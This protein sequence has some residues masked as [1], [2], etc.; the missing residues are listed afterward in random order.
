VG[1]LAHSADADKTDLDFCAHHFTQGLRIMKPHTYR[2]HA[3]PAMAAI[4][5]IRLLLLMPFANVQNLV[6][7][8]LQPRR[9]WRMDFHAHAHHE[10][11][12]VLNG[13]IFVEIQGKTLT[14]G[15]GETL[16]Y[17]QRVAHREWTSARAPVESHFMAFD[18][19]ELPSPPRLLVTDPE[20]RLIQL[21]RWLYAERATDPSL[22]Q[23]TATLYGQ[24]LVAEFLRLAAQPADGFVARMRIF[25]R[26]HLADEITL[27][28]LAAAAAL[29]RFHFIRRY[30]AQTG[31]TPMADLRL[32]RL[33]AARDLL[34]TTSLPLKE[35]APRCGLRDEFHLSRL[36]RRQF[37]TSPG[38]FRRRRQG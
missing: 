29:S 12:V 28:D 31:R 4:A 36:F 9:T 7:G 23:P 5:Y 11:I 21:A 27:E 22:T 25:M 6:I 16:W 3:L 32:T 1:A 10:M 24:A 14:A 19:P 26:Q 8:H 33:A 18:W 37:G 17:P 13:R 30:R 35:V 34:L 15:A 2:I 38:Q 20:G